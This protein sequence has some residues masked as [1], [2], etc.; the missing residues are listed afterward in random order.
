MEVLLTEEEEERRG[1]GISTTGAL[2][3]RSFAST[4]EALWP[5]AVGAL[6]A[7]DFAFATNNVKLRP[8]LPDLL[9]LPTLA[10]VE[11]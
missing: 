10:T 9:P 3:S 8:S 5:P 6:R 7:P 4:P 1:C 11:R 2:T